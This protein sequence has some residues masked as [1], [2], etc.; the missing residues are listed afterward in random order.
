ML[1]DSAMR[2]CASVVHHDVRLNA[3]NRPISVN[4]S[5]T[6]ARTPARRSPEHPA[7]APKHCSGARR[8]KARLG[9]ITTASTATAIRSKSKQNSIEIR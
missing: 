6:H 4:V 5:S 8:V 1:R 2:N 3:I 9:R 7:H